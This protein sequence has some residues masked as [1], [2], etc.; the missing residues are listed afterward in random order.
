MRDGR[1]GGKLLAVKVLAPAPPC[2]PRVASEKSPEPWSHFIPIRFY[3]TMNTNQPQSHTAAVGLKAVGNKLYTL[4]T[5]HFSDCDR[6]G[7]WN[8]LWWKRCRF[9]H[10]TS[11]DQ[12]HAAQ[13]DYISSAK[14]STVP[15]LGDSRRYSGGWK[16]GLLIALNLCPDPQNL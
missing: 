14:G 16:K 12:R 6:E 9:P 15:Q 3:W 7:F 10:R 8:H 13:E 4:F 5:G 11:I 1:S 2:P